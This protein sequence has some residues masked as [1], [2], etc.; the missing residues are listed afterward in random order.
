MFSNGLIS[1]SRDGYTISCVLLATIGLVTAC[2]GG[3]I[4]TARSSTCRLAHGGL[5]HYACIDIY[6]W[7]EHCDLLR[8]IRFQPMNPSHLSIPVWL[9]LFFHRVTLLRDAALIAS[10]I[11]C[12]EPCSRGKR[13]ERTVVCMR[14]PRTMRACLRATVPAM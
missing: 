9:G 11:S 3:I 5:I 4:Q 1:R 7:S 14:I 13:G 2:A 10:W 12:S 8:S 6:L